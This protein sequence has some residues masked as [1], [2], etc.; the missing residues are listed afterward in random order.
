MARFINPLIENILI[1]ANIVNAVASGQDEAVNEIV[2][3]CQAS[4]V[5]VMLPHTVQK[6]LDHPNTPLAVKEARTQFLETHFVPPAESELRQY[7]ELILAVMGNSL[8]KNVAPDLA[9][10]SEAAK[11]G[12]YF[13]TNDKW[14]LNRR[15]G[16]AERL[17]LE[18]VNPS[19]F[20]ERIEQA[21]ERNKRFGRPDLR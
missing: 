1:D 7:R 3:L 15:D 17:P 16:I 6:E 18:V 13:I 21:R 5:I 8:E 20:L 2:R 14:L 9:H 12:G 10:V 11:Y 19:T 4:E